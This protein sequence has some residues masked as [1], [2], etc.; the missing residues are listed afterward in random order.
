MFRTKALNDIFRARVQNPWVF[1][2]L[3]MVIVFQSSTVSV[4]G[5][6]RLNEELVPPDVTLPEGNGTP[7][8]SPPAAAASQA[9]VPGYTPGATAPP[10]YSKAAAAAALAAAATK[11]GQAAS[12]PVASTTS[13]GPEP[14]ADDAKKPDPI[15]IIDT[16]KGRIVIRLFRSLAPK[17]VANFIDLSS[18]G[19]YNGLTFHRVEPGFCIQ[20]GDP[21]GDGSGV[22]HEPGT[23]A[24]RFLPLETN[25]QLKHN[26]AGVV[27]MARFPKNPNTASCQFYITLGAKASLDG[28]YSIFGGV[29]DGMDVVNRIAKG[30]KMTT[31][32]VQEQTAN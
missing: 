30:D 15:A 28:Q 7:T 22:Y 2:A 11:A 25:P 19:F 18:K 23:N 14:S 29:I 3:L 6:D 21:N 1:S 24:M 26:A 13:S 31:V 5:S 10:P 20:G 4:R 9:A 8:Y 12:S 17:T 27:A 16:E 32:S